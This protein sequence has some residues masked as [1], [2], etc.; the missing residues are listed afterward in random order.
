MALNQLKEFGNEQLHNFNTYK[1]SLMKNGNK[2]LHL[3][4]DRIPESVSNTASR[5]MTTVSHQSAN[6]VAWA[7]KHPVRAAIYG[8]IGLG[9]IGATTLFARR[10]RHIEPSS[11][12]SSNFPQ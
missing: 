7:K 12:D 3:V 8:V 6:A 5:A 2:S 9:I 11:P 10:R 4:S 1:N